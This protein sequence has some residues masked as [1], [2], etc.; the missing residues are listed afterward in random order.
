[1]SYGLCLQG[2]GK[3]RLSTNLIPRELLTARLIRRKKPWA[4]M[5]LTL[6]LLGISFNYL[7]AW[8]RWRATLTERFEAETRDVD[9]IKKQSDDFVSKDKE[10]QAQFDQAKVLG[11]AV[12]GGADA[13]FLVLE[14]VK[15]VQSALPEPAVKDLKE[16]N[17]VPYEERPELYIESVDSEFFQDL[18]EY[19]TDE[20]K[21]RY[22]AFLKDLQ[23]AKA[24]AEGRAPVDAQLPS[25]AAS[26]GEEEAAEGES[27]STEP[28][29]E[30]S[31]PAAEGET[32]AAAPEGEAAP[33]EA[34]AAAGEEAAIDT[35]A[36]DAMNFARPGWVVQIKGFHFYSS[37]S[38]PVDRGYGHLILTLL[39]QLENG[40]VELPPA[41]GMPPV[42]FT[43][44]ELGIYYP[45]VVTSQPEMG[46]MVPDLNYD[47]A[48]AAANP[49]AAPRRGEGGSVSE[50]GDTGGV[51]KVSKQAYEFT[52][53]F[54]WLETRA[55]ERMEARR[56]KE[57][58]P[59]DAPAAEQPS[60]Q[61]VGN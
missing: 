45:M 23:V 58:K 51:P 31:A 24:M 61:V 43:M 30:S 52:V 57:L 39:N 55:S 33:A 14:L 50:G 28:A 6:F 41:P 36:V 49:A 12:V 20:V 15:A 22:S 40:T 37:K 2:L 7:F 35:A 18:S 1:M 46:I 16:A 47:P 25:E 10:L 56:N 59:D 38:N 5:A 9:S 53:Q 44:K 4:L 54:V 19:T 32:A 8:N 21:G 17:K 27:E 34:E 42:S 48:K 26:S 3:S 11:Q 29:A 13:R 60:N